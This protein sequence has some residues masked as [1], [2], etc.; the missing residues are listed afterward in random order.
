[1]PDTISLESK[2]E[3]QQAQRT[4]A[5][6]NTAGAERAATL[7]KA[8]SSKE[9]L[10]SFIDSHISMHM[11]VTCSFTDGHNKLGLIDSH[12]KQAHGVNAQLY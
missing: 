7:V 8:N 6:G 4:S 10:C 12:N 2:R 1:M 5:F 3:T 9:D 11:G